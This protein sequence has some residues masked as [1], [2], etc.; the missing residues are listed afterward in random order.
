MAQQKTGKA[1]VLTVREFQAKLCQCIQLDPGAH[2]IITLTGLAYPL[3]RL[4]VGVELVIELVD[5][6]FRVRGIFEKWAALAEKHRVKVC[7]HTHSNRC[8][9]MNGAM[10]MH[11]SGRTLPA[12]LLLLGALL[13]KETAVVF[14]AAAALFDLY[15]REPLRWR[16]YLRSAQ[17]CQRRGAENWRHLRLLGR[18]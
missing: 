6:L 4:F 12:C 10:L 7:Y 9:G 15:R 17:H 8:M 3:N 16:K 1:C 11:L 13:S 18:G 14:I 5:N 2:V